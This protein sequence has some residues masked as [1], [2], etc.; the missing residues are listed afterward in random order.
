[1]KARCLCLLSLIILTGCATTKPDLVR[2]YGNQQGIVAQPPVI[3]I[4][5]ALGGRLSYRDTGVEA[6]P[7]PLNKLVFS[8]Y[9]RLELEIDPLTMAPAESSLQP[10]G[11]AKTI[12]GVDFYGRVLDVL[13]EAAGYRASVPGVPNGSLE[14]RYYTFSYDWRLDVVDSARRLDAFI[15]QIRTDYGNPDLE[16]D[17]VA[18]YIDSLISHESK[19]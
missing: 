18:R 1:M 19:R 7:G 10:S 13:E 12:G 6:W 11:I 9:Q 8:N 15:E 3:I 17:I 5:G 16:V 4:H 2:L 14:R